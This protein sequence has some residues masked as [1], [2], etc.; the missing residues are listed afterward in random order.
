M[1]AHSFKVV[2][3]TRQIIAL[4]LTRLLHTP[5]IAVCLEA[6]SYRLRCERVFAPGSPSIFQLRSPGSQSPDYIAAG[7][8]PVVSSNYS[9]Y[10]HLGDT[11]L[12]LSLG[13]EVFAR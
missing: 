2:V 10:P 13:Q 6:Q 7:S 5:A 9:P 11:S 1:E 8:V 4:A 12:P 3:A